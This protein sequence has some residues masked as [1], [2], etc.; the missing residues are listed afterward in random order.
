[1]QFCVFRHLGL[2]EQRGL[3]R[4]D[5]GSQPVDSHVPGVVLDGRRIVVMRR[6][7]MPVGDEKQALVLVLEL[8]PVFQHAVIMAKVQC[9]SRAHA[10]E[11]TVFK[12]CRGIPG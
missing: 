7:R 5:A 3:R 6:Q 12:H 4:I 11:N 2:N 9:A 8:D 10:G 1:M